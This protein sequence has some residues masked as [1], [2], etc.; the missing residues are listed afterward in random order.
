MASEEF[1]RPKL[2]KD[3]RLKIHNEFGEEHFK[4]EE[5]ASGFGIYAVGFFWTIVVR[6]LDGE[7]GSLP[8]RFKDLDVAI[9][10]GNRGVLA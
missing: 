9:M 1:Y 7:R 4:K 6:T 3:E 10:Q 5:N 2:T 8:I